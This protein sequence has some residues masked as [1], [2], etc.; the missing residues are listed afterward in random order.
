MKAHLVTFIPAGTSKTG[1]L[2][3]QGRSFIPGVKVKQSKTGTELD[4][5]KTGTELYPSKSLGFFSKVKQ[6]R[7]LIW[8]SYLFF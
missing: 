8:P 7:S 4:T 1:K 5:S 3:K 6:G 2:V